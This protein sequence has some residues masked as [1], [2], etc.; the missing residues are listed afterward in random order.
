M[1]NITII[2]GIIFGVW[3]CNYINQKLGLPDD[4]IAE[5]LAEELIEQKTG[6]DIDLTPGTPE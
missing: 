5:E 3:S 2:I 6:L 1:R 4:N